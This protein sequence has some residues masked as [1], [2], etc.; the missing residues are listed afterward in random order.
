MGSGFC[1]GCEHSPCS[2][3]WIC[4]VRR[5]KRVLS[6]S[7]GFRHWVRLFAT[8]QQI[9]GEQGGG[10]CNTSKRQ[11]AYRAAE[12]Y[13][14]IYSHFNDGGRQIQNTLLK[15]QK[16]PKNASRLASVFQYEKQQQNTCKDRG[17]VKNVKFRPQKFCPAT[18][19]SMKK[20]VDKNNA[21][22]IFGL[23]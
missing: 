1:S 11:V 19:F 14:S 16:V 10:D 17:S 4:S 20:I 23:W 5:Q 8:A 9:N 21:G 13:M 12:R 6:G 3:S 2:D 7:V 22:T 15:K 18:I